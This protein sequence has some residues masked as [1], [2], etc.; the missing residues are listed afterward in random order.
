MLRWGVMQ[1]KLRYVHFFWFPCVDGLGSYIFISI[2]G[3]FINI[4]YSI[5]VCRAVQLI[6]L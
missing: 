3:D 1:R 4:I 2:G 5:F 6:K